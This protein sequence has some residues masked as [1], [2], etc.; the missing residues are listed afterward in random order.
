MIMITIVF[1]LRMIII[2]IIKLIM[3]SMEKM[4]PC[5]SND[6]V[7]Y[8][9]SDFLRLES[10]RAISSNP[11]DAFCALSSTRTEREGE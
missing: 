1:M 10:A 2:T 8:R 7:L 11:L 6:T 4:M 9:T 5:L 3:R